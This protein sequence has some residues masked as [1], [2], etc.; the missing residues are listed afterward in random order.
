[1]ASEFFSVFFFP[2]LFHTSTA[3]MGLV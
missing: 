3:R 1:M 2:L